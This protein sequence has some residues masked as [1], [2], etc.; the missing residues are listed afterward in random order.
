MVSTMVL[1]PRDRIVDI[2]NIDNFD[3]I[4]MMFD[5]NLDIQ[6]LIVSPRENWLLSTNLTLED[7]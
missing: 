7:F 2:I 6:G 3:N 5:N 4:V 1:T